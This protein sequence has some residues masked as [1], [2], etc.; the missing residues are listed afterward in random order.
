MC[1]L[2]L[3]TE[4]TGCWEASFPLCVFDIPLCRYFDAEAVL[5]AVGATALVSLA[6]TLFAMQSKV[7]SVTRS[8]PRLQGS[9]KWNV[10]NR[11]NFATQPV[12]NVPILS[13]A[14]K[15]NVLGWAARVGFSHA[16]FAICSRQFKADGIA[17]QA[18]LWLLLRS[19]YLSIKLIPRVERWDRGKPLSG[20]PSCW[21][22]L[23]S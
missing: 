13:C 16:V 1:S 11:G 5:W 22:K 6:L 23:L 21:L 2:Y 12:V 19:L 20:L 10:I 8:E 14:V 7:R 18:K 17:A 4:W 3:L 15:G 9:H